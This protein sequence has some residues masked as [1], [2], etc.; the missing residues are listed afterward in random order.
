MP[1]LYE[2]NLRDYW[3]IFLKR[4]LVFFLSFFVIFLS[5]FLYTYLQIPIFRASVL[6]NID[7][8]LGMPSD[9]VFSSITSSYW[10]SLE[11]LADYEK[12]LISRPVL[13]KAAKE[14]GWITDNHTKKQKNMIVSEINSKVMAM[15]MPGGKSSR[16]IRLSVT[17]S[18][19]ERASELANKIFDVFKK[20]NLKQKNQQVRNV[21]IFIEE[22]L[23]NV[24]SRLKDQERRLREL[25]T[26]GA[27]GAGVNI[28][29]QIYE[30][31]KKKNELMATYT[32]SHPTV[33]RLTEQIEALK[34]KLKELPKE[35]FEYGILK[36]DISINEKLYISLKQK[37]QETK[38]REAEKVDNVVLVNP[39]I[40]PLKPYYPNKSKNYTVGIML[41]LLFGVTTALVTEHLDTS[42]GRVDDIESFIKVNVLGIIPYC[43]E[44]RRESGRR[45]RGLFKGFMS[46]GGERRDLYADISIFEFE[47]HYSSIFLEAFRILA[48]NIQ[49]LFG[50][51]GR[52]KSKVILITSCNPEEGKTVVASNLSVT[53]AQM[54][55]KVLLI[56]TDTRRSTV[57]KV[58]GLKRKE[59]GFTD[60][61][62]GKIDFDG[63]VKTATDLMLGAA[64]ADKVVNKPWLNNL[65][66][67]TSGSVFPNTIN[68]FNSEKLE[69][70]L[71]YFKSKYDIIIFDT[72]PVLAV[73]EPS[74]I[75]PRM[76]GVVLVYKA[77]ATSSLALRRA[78]IQIEGV[79]GK[80][81]LS[82][83]I[84]NNVTPEIGLDTYYYYS[85]KYY[86]EKEKEEKK[87]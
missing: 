36:R 26:Q 62:M 37:L 56:D 18:D 48:V 60:L 8:F 53:F 20:E 54:G 25:T 41:G 47:H 17:D 1:Q 52:I 22:T 44:R 64:G 42:I 40:A 14:L 75:I 45:Q 16:L 34:S 50:E 35:E 82:G 76:D 46:G 81:A 19:P 43:V 70:S 58:F 4:K 79:K 13:E 38:I 84:L 15:G 67:I 74:I 5:I 68:L 61:L 39:A 6:L 87:P 51:S 31:E 28:V 23:A 12:Q 78:K 73:S 55:Y 71:K 77:G 29:D 32:E 63:S 11:D 66:I 72:S 30:I 85:R 9:L 65:N 3:N 33:V 59:I 49:V 21:R 2:L 83:V 69:T 80:G 86:G 7:M 57:H 27:V 10:K 24:S